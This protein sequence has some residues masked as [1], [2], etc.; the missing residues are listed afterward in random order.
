M[1]P[2]SRQVHIKPLIFGTLFGLIVAI[3]ITP[4]SNAADPETG[5][6][7]SANDA[8]PSTN[9][10]PNYSGLADLI[11][12]ICDDALERFQGFYGPT[13][14][15]VEPFNSIG[16]YEKGKQSELGMT[17]AD[18]MT[19]VINND[20]LANNRVASGMT[21]Q[22]LHGIL[23]EVDGYLRIHISGVN[24]DGERTSYVVSVEMSEPIYRAL[25]TYL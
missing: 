1:K 9:A 15:K 2:K 7:L 23:Q 3:M 4:N 6:T 20:T 19:A 8:A 18:Q 22:K 12:M 21:T 25:H 11:T 24:S 14:V 17:L 13:V 16:F 5:D 10:Y